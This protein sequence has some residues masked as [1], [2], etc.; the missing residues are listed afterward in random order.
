MAGI[1]EYLLDLFFPVRAQCLGCGDERGCDEPFLCDVC[2]RLLWPINAVVQHDDWQARGL[3]SACFAYRYA[4]PVRGLI[5]A[6]KYRGVSMLA[7]SMAADLFRLMVKRGI[8]PYDA[9]VPVPLYPAR[10]RKR[11]YNQSAL[12]AEALSRRCGIPVNTDAVRRIRNTR[13]Q[14]KLSAEKR[15][16]NTNG[17]F[18]AGSDVSGLRILLI[19]DVITTGSTMCACAEILRGAGARNVDAMTFAG[20]CRYKISSAHTYRLRKKQH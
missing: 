1:R 6:F 11:G 7:E 20:A 16:S 18:S 9:I 4:R 2:R 5:H 12:L 8:G 13:Q 10:Q 14:A 19:D 15:H 3:N 17:A